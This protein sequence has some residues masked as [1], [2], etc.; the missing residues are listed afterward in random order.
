MLLA[1]LIAGHSQDNVI[2]SSLFVVCDRCSLFASWP[3]LQHPVTT[4][5]LAVVVVA[6]VVAVVATMVVTAVAVV[7]KAA[8]VAVVATILTCAAVKVASLMS[9]SKSFQP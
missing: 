3:G 7:T 6:V 4:T 1:R 2:V 9:V 8:A 5:S